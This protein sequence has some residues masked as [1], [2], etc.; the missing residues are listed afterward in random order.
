MFLAIGQ[1]FPFFASAGLKTHEI[2]KQ[3]LTN[4][5]NV[6]LIHKYTYIYH[7]LCSYI[8]MFIYNMYYYT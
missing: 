6:R 5:L 2:P 1:E 7:T 8:H 3:K 4:D